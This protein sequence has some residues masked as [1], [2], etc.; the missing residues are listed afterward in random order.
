MSLAAVDVVRSLQ[1]PYEGMDLIPVI[2]AIVEQVRP[3]F[4]AEAIQT[5]I[6]KDPAMKYLHPDIEWHTGVPGLE[7]VVR[8][9]REL[10]LWWEDWLNTWESYTYRGLEY[11]ELS[12]EWVL[13]PADLEVRGRGGLDL[14]A[15]IFQLYHVRENKVDVWRISTSEAVL[16]A[17]AER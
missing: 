17:A 14:S 6:A 1:L 9:L 3:D 15:H 13:M 2:G 4:D 12:D 8:G 5:L 7:A 11:R 16:L 10:A